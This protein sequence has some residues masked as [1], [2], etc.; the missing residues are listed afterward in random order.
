[1]I[2]LLN[3]SENFL[4]NPESLTLTAGGA[5]DN[6]ISYGDGCELGNGY[7]LIHGCLSSAF[8]VTSVS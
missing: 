8:D 7:D 6:S 4:S 1:L 3:A 5:G 2:C